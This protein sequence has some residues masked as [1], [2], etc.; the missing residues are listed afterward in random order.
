MKSVVFVAVALS[1]VAAAQEVDPAPEI[2][3]FTVRAGY[4]VEVVTNR[5]RDARFIEFDDRGMLY[6]SRPREGE[7]ATYRDLD[8]DGQF[9]ERTSFVK[10]FPAVH[11]LCWHDGWMWFAAS[12]TV[13][14]A[15]DLDGDGEADEN[16]EVLANLPAGGGHWW[17]SLLVTDEHIYTSIGESENASDERETPRQKIWRYSR[18]GS[19]Q[20]LFA[21]G[22]RNTEKLRLRP[23]TSEVWGCDHGS[24]WF[25]GLYNEGDSQPI[26]DTMPPCELNKYVEGGFYGHPFLVGNRVPR[27]E[28]ENLPDLGSLAEKT[29]VPEWCFGAHWAPNGFSFVDPAINAKAKAFPADH[30]GDLFV[31]FHGS[32]NSTRR[33]GYQIARVLFDHGKPYGLLTI[34]STLDGEEVV[35]RPVDVTQGPDG[36][37]YWSDD[38]TGRVYRLK[39]VGPAR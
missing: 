32:W 34:V 26:T 19:G 37:L 21:S 39:W 14:R 3:R 15:R 2:A 22:I 8:K 11:A 17:R 6:V 5:L 36:C 1:S 33:V 38:F 29:I 24:D 31:A 27:R 35:G 16:I 12:G 20:T 10:G 9:E 18:S 25:G 30:A 4:Q 13:R 23:G 7:I 28:F